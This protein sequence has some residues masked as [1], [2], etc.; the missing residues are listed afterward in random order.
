MCPAERPERDAPE[1]MRSSETDQQS[2]RVF[3]P[4][5]FDA[6]TGD[7]VNEQG[8]T[9]LEPQVARLLTF[10]LEHPETLVTRDDLIEHAW[11]GRIVSDHAINRC[12]SIL[13]GKLSPE[14][15][16]AYIETV[17]RRGF[18]GHF[19]RSDDHAESGPAVIPPS[20]S[21]EA[22][23][24]GSDSVS[25]Y[26]RWVGRF[27]SRPM[28]LAA[29]LLAVAVL[30]LQQFRGPV[31]ATPPAASGEA[32]MLAILPFVTHDNSEE[33]GFFASGVHDDL[34]TRLAQFQSLRV[35]S[36]TSVQEYR[37]GSTG[38]REIGRALGADAILEGGIQR[39][40][41]RIRVNAQLIDADTDVHLWAEQFDRD[42]TPENLFEIQAEIARAIAVALRSTLTAQDAAQLEVIPTH[43]MAAYRA[44]H[45][46]MQLRTTMTIDTPE[47]VAAL[48]RA[49]TLDPQFVR[50][51]SE[52]AGALSFMVFSNRDSEALDRLERVLARIG[53]L[54]PRSAEEIFAQS[55]Y[56]YYVLTDYQ[57][58]G[59]LIDQALV[60]R[61][62]DLQVL[63]VKTWI[64]RRLGDF[65][66]AVGTLEKV[67]ALDP[68]NDYWTVRLVNA[69]ILVH[70]YDEAMS[71][72]RN[73]PFSSLGLARRERTLAI[74]E[75]G[76]PERLIDDLRELELEY[77]RQMDPFDLWQ[78]QIAARD[79]SGAARLLS[80]QEQEAWADTDWGGLSFPDPDLARLIT[81]WFQE[82]S[83]SVRASAAALRRDLVEAGP[84]TRSDFSGRHSLA[85]GVTAAVQ[86]RGEDALRFVRTWFRE[87]P[88]DQA[89]LVHGRHVAC[90][91]LGM[92]GAA[93]EAVEC[94]RR[95]VVEPSLVMPFLEPHLPYYDSIRS[96]STFVR[97]M[98]ESSAQR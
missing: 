31:D 63:E 61:P 35:I 50:A 14:D 56:T 39:V 7:L 32:P 13:R 12:I 82:P 41:D 3:G 54:A 33:S 78:A 71:E 4:W 77:G 67:R 37:D 40:G 23:N 74:R 97:W 72:I 17:T 30:A 26:R 21:P 88:I 48:E 75:T 43:N 84:L 2:I 22:S 70:R 69:L 86:G 98:E 53:A 92:A 19:P 83:E 24:P 44:Y 58:A 80:A 59:E 15:R 16:S 49:V 66:G 76:A 42:F 90:R 55:Y 85:L 28:L 25:V 64:Q 29:L 18:I 10:F 47:Y 45:E 38:I 95:G 60:L 20:S 65:E 81:R 5:R 6:A 51:W 46:A 62:N 11:D 93:T 27:A 1:P 91:V 79:Y 94:L 68:L 8:M 57:R 36:R 89:E 52:L 87:A 34:L 73:A 9:R 96:D